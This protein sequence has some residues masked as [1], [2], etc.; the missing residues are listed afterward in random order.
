MKAGIWVATPAVPVNGAA[1]AA[2]ICAAVV[3]PSQAAEGHIDL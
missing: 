1:V 2:W 3:V